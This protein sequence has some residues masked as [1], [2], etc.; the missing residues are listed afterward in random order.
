MRYHQFT[1][2]S[3]LLP[4]DKRPEQKCTR[5]GY[6]SFVFDARET[7]HIVQGVNFGESPSRRVKRSAAMLTPSTRKPATTTSA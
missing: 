4:D 1:K 7:N 3:C 6:P 5:D 2:N